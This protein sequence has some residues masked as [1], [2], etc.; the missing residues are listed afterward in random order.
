MNKQEIERIVKKVIK[1][2]YSIIDKVYDP[3]NHSE[4]ITELQKYVNQ[5]D[6]ESIKNGVK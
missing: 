1:E 3:N 4:S 5:E 6:I 2:T